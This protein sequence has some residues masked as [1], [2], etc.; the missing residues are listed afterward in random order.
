MESERHE[1]DSY[2]LW[3]PTPE[4][5]SV[6]RAEM[7]RVMQGDTS[8]IVERLQGIES[9]AERDQQIVDMLGEIGSATHALCV[10][11]DALESFADPQSEQRVRTAIRN[12]EQLTG[13]QDAVLDLFEGQAALP[14]LSP[15]DVAE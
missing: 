9:A 6:S 12:I 1:R 14:E 8:A 7:E 4:M 13:L 2:G 5:R 11:I 10:M 3:D 15:E